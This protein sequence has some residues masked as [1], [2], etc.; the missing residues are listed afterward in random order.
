MCPDEKYE[1]SEFA[2]QRRYYSLVYD[3][4]LVSPIFTF[5][6]VDG[7]VSLGITFKFFDC[8]I[9]QKWC[10]FF[11]NV[12]LNIKEKRDQLDMAPTLLILA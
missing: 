4:S 11:N 7:P 6:K 9:Q 5:C 10:Q 12:P 8:Y 2:V 1:A 3:N